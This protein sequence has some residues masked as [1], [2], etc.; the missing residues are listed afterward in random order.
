MKKRIMS[1]LSAALLLLSM[2]ACGAEKS[3][4][5]QATQPKETPKKNITV[6]AATVP[7]P[8]ELEPSGKL[9]EFDVQI[10]DLELAKDYKG[11]P[12]ALIKFSFTNNSEKNTSAI[13]A[14][15]CKAFQNGLQLETAI[16]ADD[17]IYNAN[18]QMKEIQP[19]A[20]IDVTVAY[21]LESE[22]APVEFEVSESFSF[23][24]EKLGKTFEISEDGTTEMSVAPGSDVAQAVG[25]YSVA[26]V[27]YRLGQDYKGNKAIVF[28][29]GFTNNSDKDASYAFSIDFSVFQ[30]GVELETAI[31]MDDSSS[32]ITRNVKPGAGIA[33]TTAFLLTSDTSPVELEIKPYFGN[34]NDEIKTEINI[35]G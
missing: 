19:G 21:K 17:S 8:T 30:D 32:N 14:L 2:T 12:A 3:G 34:S 6:P 13:L 35:A 25:D 27:S 1:L 33:V 20:S 28:E 18:D 7:V 31:L 24:D 15:Q 26:V 22:K 23:K 10:N 9:G 4:S 16:I 29:I 5:G 11:E